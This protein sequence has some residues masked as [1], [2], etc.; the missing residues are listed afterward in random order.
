MLLAERPVANISFIINTREQLNK[1][2][3]KKEMTGGN[4]G[5]ML[6][7]DKWF[8]FNIQIIIFIILF[9]FQ[10]LDTSIFSFLPNV[11]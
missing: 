6:N 4:M 10:S 9:V 3:K 11:L 5:N 7:W 2:F 1:A 8:A